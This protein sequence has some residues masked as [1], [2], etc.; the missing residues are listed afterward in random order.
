MLSWIR[1][2]MKNI[3]ANNSTIIMA[4]GDIV[5]DENL[6][7]ELSKSKQGSKLF[8]KLVNEKIE[9]CKKSL[10]DKDIHTFEILINTFFNYGLV[11]LPDEIQM[12][13]QF[14]KLLLAIYKNDINALN[15]AADNIE[16]A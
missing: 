13:L 6:I 2:K 12:K 15:D 16:E 1:Q 8:Q 10:L 11:E 3:T 5:I 7:S 4:G 14:Y 9:V